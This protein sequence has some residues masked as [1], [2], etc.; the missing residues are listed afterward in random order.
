MI[1]DYVSIP[2]GA[3]QHGFSRLDIPMRAQD[4]EYQKIN[5]GDD[6]WIGSGAIVL[7]DVGNH[8]IIGAGSIITKPVPDYAIVSGNPV[9]V[10]GDRRDT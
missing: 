9:R 7:A 10:T 2:S 6:C 3:R 5:I 1:A 4:G 8:A